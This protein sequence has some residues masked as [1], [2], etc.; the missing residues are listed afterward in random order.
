MSGLKKIDKLLI[1]NRGEIA[2][3]IIKTAK[4]LGIKTVAVYSDA[5]AN[6]LHVKMADEAV[7]LGPAPSR[8]S[9]LKGELIIAA[10]IKLNVDAIHPGYGFL[11]ENSQFCRLCEQH[12]IIFVGPPIG[13]IE[14]MGSKSAAKHIME[15]AG[16][17]LVPGYHGDDQSPQLL[18]KHADNMGYPVL[19]KAAAG[20]GGKGMRQVSDSKEFFDALDAA[21][22]EAMSGFGDDIML[23]EKYLIQPRHV[24]IQVFCDSHENGVY[25]FERDC[26]VQRRHQKVI[27]EAPAPGMTEELRQ[28]MGQAAL[29]AAQAIGYIGA[30]TVEFLLDSNNQFFFMEMNTRLQVEHPV[31]EMITGQDLVEWQLHVAKGETLPMQQ[32]QLQ[33]NGHAF[34]A[35]IYAE[36]PNNQFLPSTGTLTRLIPPVEG[37][38]VRVDTGVLEGDDVS[39]FY[40]PMIAKLIVW[41]HDRDKALAKLADALS[42]YQVDGVTTNIDFLYNLATHPAFK[43]AQ[44]S[45]HFID[46]HETELFV[47]DALQ[48]ALLTPLAV[49]YLLLQRQALTLA[50]QKQTSAIQS[51]WIKH[52]HWRMNEQYSEELN[53]YIQQQNIA[54]QVE[55]FLCSQTHQQAFKVTTPEGCF[56]C[57]GELKGDHFS[58]TIDKQQVEATL[59]VHQGYTSLFT[60]EYAIQCKLNEPDLGLHDADDH[61]GGF[62]APM[63]GT[64]V[65]QV[66]EE[67]S[68]VEKGQTLIVMEAM[69][70]EHAIKAPKAGV[71]KK[72]HFVAGDLVDGGAILLDFEA[73]E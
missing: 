34:E 36:D 3:R 21:K 67:N 42:H 18:K 64:I 8:E 25:L 57:V 4:K 11:S 68:E 43:E 72:F 69:K 15:Q 17:P 27:E 12:N 10:A 13:A 51:P 5:D 26:S 73:K 60:Q 2:C 1:A 49:T 19:L 50:S 32:G 30:G 44:L 46:E 40:D 29:T 48:R 24:E 55:Y 56:E 9:Y 61:H 65:S 70:M 14:A 16:V 20:G 33:I 62:E 28:Q 53:V 6:A 41:D 31:T 7:R 23:V 66:V 54:V 59:Q 63:N 52:N 58:A 38:E 45:T 22:R 35:R 71:V 37:D 39:P 47:S